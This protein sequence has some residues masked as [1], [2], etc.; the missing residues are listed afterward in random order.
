MNQPV[1]KHLDE[2]VK[3][4]SFSISD[5]IGY[6]VPFFIGS[7]FDSLFLVPMIGIVVVF[8]VKRL[9]KRLPRFYGLRCLYWSLPTKRFNRMLGINLPPSHKHL[10]MK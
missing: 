8:L 7:F 9:L 6:S 3:V 10:W 1:L 4:L 2:P 5:L